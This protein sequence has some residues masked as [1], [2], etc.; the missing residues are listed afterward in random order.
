MPCRREAEEGLAARRLPLVQHPLPRLLRLLQRCL[1]AQ[2]R[3]APLALQ[4]WAEGVVAEADAEGQLGLLLPV[5]RVRE[6]LVREHHLPAW[7]VE[8]GEL[9]R[10][11][12]SAPDS[13]VY[14]DQC[15]RILVP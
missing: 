8:A 5:R 6:R 12:H 14:C 7:E 4:A 13:V 1:P 15:G 11:R 9:H 10:L 3:L 2:G